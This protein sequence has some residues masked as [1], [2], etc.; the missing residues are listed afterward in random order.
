M[1][2]LLGM[3]TAY[4]LARIFVFEAS[5]RSMA[6]EFWRFGLVNLA[7]LAIVWFVS[8]SL[9][10]VVFPAIGFVWRAEDVAHFSGVIAP[11]AFSYFAHRFYTFAGRVR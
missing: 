6:S 4:A 5:G 1:A 2:Y 3:T 7:S 9:L 10:R 11:V 8:V